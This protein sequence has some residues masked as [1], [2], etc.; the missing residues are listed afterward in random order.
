M[1]PSRPLYVALILALLAGMGPLA[2]AFGEF[3]PDDPFQR[4]HTL[5]EQ[6]KSYTDYVRWS[7]FEEASHFVEAADRAAFVAAMPNFDDVRF[8]DWEAAPWAMADEE[9]RTAT[10]EVTYKGYGTR[11]LIELSVH[12]TQ[13]WSRTN[14]NNWT[15]KS[16]FRDL[17]RLAAQAGH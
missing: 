14:G 6:Q 3:R 11:T 17:D 2:C 15:V 7:K 10:I 1:R 5:S 8:T 9:K 4:Q 12:E 16:T 13:E